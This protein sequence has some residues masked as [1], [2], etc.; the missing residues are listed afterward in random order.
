MDLHHVSTIGLIVLS[1]LLNFH[2]LGLLVFTLLN[3]SSPLLHASKLANTLD[4]RRAKVA[5]FA[6]FA[7][8]FAGTRVLVFPYVVCRAAV[9]NAWRDIPRLTQIRLFF[10]IWMSFIALLLVLAAMQAWWFVAIV[11]ILKQ[12]TAGNEKGLQAEVLR[13]DFSQQVRAVQT[14]TGA[15]T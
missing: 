9:Y 10:W 1:Y 5:L 3:V 4:W 12:V 14:R 6:L 11:K 15:G 13:R 7:V 2:T 8:V